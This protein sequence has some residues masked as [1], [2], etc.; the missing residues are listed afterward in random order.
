M[1]FVAMTTPIALTAHRLEEMGVP[2]EAL[3]SSSARPTHKANEYVSAELL[4]RERAAADFREC[5][6]EPS[7]LERGEQIGEGS[8]GE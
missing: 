1:R 5:V 6:I 2:V 8:E 7:E 3:Q 4:E